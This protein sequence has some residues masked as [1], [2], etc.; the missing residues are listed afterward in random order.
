MIKNIIGWAFVLA[1]YIAFGFYVGA[2][3]ALA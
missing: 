2:T 3:I 1:L